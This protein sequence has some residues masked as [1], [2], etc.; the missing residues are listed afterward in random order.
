MG[1]ATTAKAT[2][3]RSGGARVGPAIDSAVRSPFPRVPRG[4]ER[5]I[6]ALTTVVAAAGAIGL[7]LFVTERLPS[8]SLFVSVALALLVVLPAWLMLSSNYA[9]TLGVLALYLGLVD[10]VLKLKLNT[11]VA[12]LGRDLLLYSIVFGAVLRL[13][14]S[15]RRIRIPPLSGYAAA[16]TVIALVQVLNPETQDFAHA[17]A[18]LRPHLEFVPLFFFGYAVMR[19][20]NR[21][22]WYLLLLC[23]VAAVNGVVGFTQFDLTPEELSTW[24]PGYAERLEGTG[25]LSPRTFEGESTSRVRPPAL[26]SDMGFGG[27]IAVLAIPA[28]LTL[29][30]AA[31][32]PRAL[33]VCGPLAAGIIL[34]VVTS[35]SRS[36]VVAAVVA[37]LAFFG[38][39]AMS[40]RRAIA[41]L[42]P[43]AG[44]ALTVVIVSVLVASGNDPEFR[45][46]TIA[47]SKLLATTSDSRS[48][49]LAAIPEY[50]TSF[51]LGKGLGLVGPAAGFAGNVNQASAL[52]GESQF[53]FFLVELGVAG[54]LIFAALQIKLLA[55]ATRLRRIDDPEL[56]LLLAGCTAPLFAVAALWITGPIS[57]TSPT[58]PYFWFTAGILAFWLIE[59][60]R[61]RAT[62]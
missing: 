59:H 53:T 26:G 62:S 43:A 16:F 22:R 4:Q 6:R 17:I 21:L 46:D 23:T 18:A 51:P 15:R 37:L 1:T 3:N 41:L 8:Q 48:G 57:A 34:G 19:T 14:L 44:V 10:G 52:N 11:P 13:L 24:G 25:A 54:L 42:G 45:Y 39:A 58:A 2:L 27:V 31:A 50:A 12:T 28:L 5:L 40:Q 56:R 36:V 47:P 35:Q 9:V 38:L 20:S 30:G 32:R 7:S 49:T 33:L 55:L 61:S 29:L 60:K